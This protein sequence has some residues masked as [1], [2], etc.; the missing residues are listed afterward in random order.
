MTTQTGGIYIKRDDDNKETSL[1][2]QNK[3]IGGPAWRFGGS[4]Y[5]CNPNGDGDILII[6]GSTL[7]CL[8][9]SGEQSEIK[10]KPEVEYKAF[11]K[12]H[13][14]P[15]G[16]C[17]YMVAGGPRIFTKLIKVHVKSGETSV[18]RA[19]H[20]AA[21][22]TAYYSFPEEK[23]WDTTDGAKAYGYYYPPLNKEYQGPED[24]QPPLLVKVHG[25]PTSA[26]SPML[27]LK[28]QYFTSRGFAVLDV[29]YR[30]SSGYGREYRDALKKNGVFP[31]LKTA[32]VELSS[33]LTQERLIL[34]GC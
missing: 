27:D 11:S 17:A 15:N 16:Q 23:T 10:I 1:C 22:D 12:M 34:R 18:I 19:S 30:G 13:Y 4:P 25:G 7:A 29:N 24:E 3:E 32:A 33:W 20:S 5:S 28:K 31:T 8:K 21:V 6:H 2:P 26:C 9:P 14:S